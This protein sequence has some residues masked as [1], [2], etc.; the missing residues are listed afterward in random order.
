MGEERGDKGDDDE[1]KEMGEEVE[2]VVPVEVSDE[3]FNLNSLRRISILEDNET[4]PDS[5]VKGEGMFLLT[6]I[7]VVVRWVLGSLLFSSSF[8]SCSWC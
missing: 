3:V 4:F 8:S 7:G 5:S 1:F 2:E 6:R